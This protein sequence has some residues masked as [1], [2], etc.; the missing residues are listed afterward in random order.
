MLA[1]RKLVH[2]NADGTC[3]VKSTYR[4]F[5]TG[6]L[7]IVVGHCLYVTIPGCEICASTSLL[8][9]S[10]CDIHKLMV[11]DQLLDVSGI[12][13]N[14]ELM[15]L[16]AGGFTPAAPDRIPNGRIILQEPDMGAAKSK[17]REGTL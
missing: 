13:D 6:S 10:L 2:R 4:T 14:H 1:S 8:S 16:S 11:C 9:L 3:M 5:I 12:S 7:Q 17:P 15:I